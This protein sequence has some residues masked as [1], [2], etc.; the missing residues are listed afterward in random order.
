M[1]IIY[2]TSFRMRIWIAAAFFLAVTVLFTGAFSYTVSSGVIERNA[3]ELNRVAMEK[4]AQALEQR[5]HHV[6]MSVLSMAVNPDYRKAVGLEISPEWDNYFYH[7]SMVQDTIAQLKL[8]ES[9]IDSILVDSPR[10][11]FYSTTQRRTEVGFE[12]TKYNELFQ[13][14]TTRHIE[15]WLPQ[16]TDPFFQDRQQVV[17]FVTEGA[18]NDVRK[19]IYIIANVRVNRVRELVQGTMK[20]DQIRYVLLT[21]EGQPFVRSGVSDELD[22]QALQHFSSYAS[23]AAE[24]NF[25]FRFGNDTYFV[26]FIKL[27]LPNN[28]VLYG[29]LSKSEMLADLNTI[30]WLLTVMVVVLIGI[31][32]VFLDLITRW[33]LRPLNYLRRLMKQVGHTESNVRFHSQYD[34][35][36]THLG[37]QFNAMMDRIESLFEEVKQAENEKH[38]AEISALQSQTNPHFLYNTLNTIYW[39]SQMNQLKDV[40]EMVLSLSKLFQLG[41]NRGHVQTTL[42]NELAHA[43]QYMIIQQLCYRDLFAY[44]IDVAPEVDLHTPIMKVIL[45]PLVENSILHGFKDRNTGGVI[46]IRVRSA[47]EK[48]ILE[49]YDNGMGFPAETGRD[50]AADAEEKRARS[51]PE[52]RTGSAGS[53]NFALRNLAQ[54]ISLCYGA[55]GTIHVSSSVGEGTTIT[56]VLPIG[57]IRM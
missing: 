35:E 55:A 36:I 31:S 11:D 52:Q 21:D 51:L 2:K 15:L 7:F 26:N 12:D 20:N 41:L 40:Q 29:M 23:K 47:E 1:N 19:S 22:E 30:K 32:L 18:L 14:Q 42:R 57:D 25:E 8:I 27:Q 28:L 43:E 54:R 48:L 44:S 56:L 24:G 16:H 46:R 10:G 50:D 3:Y 34:D 38:K 39:K 37:E 33:S 5:F 45:Q 6:R 4:T 49:V 17:S 53:S 9:W 13:Q